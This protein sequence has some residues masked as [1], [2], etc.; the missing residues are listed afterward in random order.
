M[1]RQ[2][3]RY[4]NQV[5]TGRQDE[6]KYG[7][8]IFNGFVSIQ[9][10]DRTE[11]AAERL[12]DQTFP[13]RNINRRHSISVNVNQPVQPVQAVNVF[14]AVNVNQ[15]AEVQDQ[16]AI[17]ADDTIPNVPTAKRRRHASVDSRVYIAPPEL[18]PTIDSF[19]G[20]GGVL[21]YR[22]S[23]HSVNKKQASIVPIGSIA[24]T[25]TITSMQSSSVDIGS[26]ATATATTSTSTNMQLS[27]FD[28]ST[29]ISTENANDYDEMEIE[30]NVDD[31][32]G[33]SQQNDSTDSNT[34]DEIQTQNSNVDTTNSAAE[35]NTFSSV[36]AE[37]LKQMEENLHKLRENLGIL[38][39]N[40][41][42]CTHS[43]F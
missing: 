28:S 37:Q 15:A 10:H 16:N 3:Q 30:T 38:K 23:F 11:T 36:S 6:E 1:T 27:S 14:Q 41:Y 7:I 4:L 32:G 21:N 12:I 17:D 34:H 42:D 43:N 19:R 5:N 2:A 13:R 20:A 35:N 22:S 31:A 8:E 25:S 33:I 26:F 29:D 39:K 9:R 40:I 18:R 24:R